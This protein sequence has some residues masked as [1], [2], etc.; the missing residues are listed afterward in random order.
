MSRVL[1]A[2]QRQRVTT[3]RQSAQEAIDALVD[4]LYVDENDATVDDCDLDE[5]RDAAF[6]A[7]DEIVKGADVAIESVMWEGT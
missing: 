3:L 4:A 7:I 5:P 2:E 1:L 6:D